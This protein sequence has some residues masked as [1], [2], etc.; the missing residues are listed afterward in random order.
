[1][2]CVS[3]M[4]NNKLILHT[5]SKFSHE[6]LI[7]ILEKKCC[8]SGQHIAFYF[9]NIVSMFPKLCTP[10]HIWWRSKLPHRSILLVLTEKKGIQ[11]TMFPFL[12]MWLSS[13]LWF[14]KTSSDCLLL[15]VCSKSSVERKSFTVQKFITI[16][17]RLKVFPPHSYNNI[18]YL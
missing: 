11:T 8:H 18:L 16:K 10:I 12:S 15:Y 2:K 6:Q 14:L 1:M 3:K 4:F 5:L 9:T 17:P 13:S 7:N